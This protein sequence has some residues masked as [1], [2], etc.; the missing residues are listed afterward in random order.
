MLSPTCSVIKTLALLSF[1]YIEFKHMVYTF[2]NYAWNFQIYLFLKAT[3]LKVR[4]QLYKW[5]TRY[6]SL[7]LYT[8]WVLNTWPTMILTLKKLC[9]RGAMWKTLYIVYGAIHLVYFLSCASTPVWSDDEAC[10]RR[11]PS[12]VEHSQLYLVSPLCPHIH[13]H[14]HY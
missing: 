1:K 10:L 12:C 5:Q 11:S 8:K 9:E 6:H 2:R 14:T 13:I 7:Y 3:Y 4:G